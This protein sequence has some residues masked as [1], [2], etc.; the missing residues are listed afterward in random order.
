M[1]LSIT[2]KLSTLYYNCVFELIDVK[3]TA[4]EVKHTPK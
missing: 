2:K 1:L 4:N 3:I